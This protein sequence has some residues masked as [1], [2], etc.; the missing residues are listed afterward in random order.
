MPKSNQLV[1]LILYRPFS[2]LSLSSSVLLS[3][4]TSVG[5]RASSEVKSE[6]L[7]AN[8]SGLWEEA[9]LEI[10]NSAFRHLLLEIVVPQHEK[11]RITRL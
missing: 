7:L 10:E 11:L 5:E 8:R 4:G 9:T 3:P 6:S 1:K 2:S